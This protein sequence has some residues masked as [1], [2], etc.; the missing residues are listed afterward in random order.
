MGVG[1]FE[2]LHLSISLILKPKLPEGKIEENTN[3]HGKVQLSDARQRRRV[4]KTKPGSR[5]HPTV[6]IKQY[7]PGYTW[8]R[9]GRMKELRI[10]H[11]AR[12]Y[13]HKWKRKV[14][15]RLTPSQARHHYETRLLRRT[16]GAWHLL[17]WELRK[18]WRLEVRAECHYRFIVYQKMYR[19]WKL[20]IVQQRIRNAKES[21]ALHHAQKKLT[22]KCFDSWQSYVASRREKSGARKTALTYHHNHVLRYCWNVWQDRLETIAHRRRLETVALQFWAFRVQAQYW[23]IWQSK[24]S[25]RRAGLMKYY[26]AVRHNNMGL[27]RR[28][29]R[30]WLMYWARR[31]QKH[32]EKVYAMR[33]YTSGLVQRTFSVWLSALRFRES[34]RDRQDRITRLRERSQKRRAFVHWRHYIEMQHEKSANIA[35][36][37][38]YHRKKL[39]RLGF[40]A[41]RLSVANKHLK[42]MRNKMATHF[43][44]KRLLCWGWLTWLARCE[45]KED[46]KQVTQC[47]AAWIHR[48]RALLRKYFHQLWEYAQWRKHRQAQYARADAH[49]YMQTMPKYLFTLKV[50]VQ[51]M[52][53]RRENKQKSLEFRRENMLARFFYGWISQQEQSKEYR[54]NERMA[55]IHCED[56]TTQCFFKLWKSKTAESLKEKKNMELAAAHYNETLLATH[57]ASWRGYIQDL[58]KSQRQE[59]EA[60]RYQ[61]RH[62]MKKCIHAWK[63]YA[64]TCREKHR[65]NSKA[66]NHYNRRLMGKMVAMWLHYVDTQRAIKARVEIMYRKKCQQLVCEL[67][68]TWRSNV[69]LQKS[70]KSSEV[71]ADRH[72]KLTLCRK[73]FTAWHRFSAIHAYKKSET[74][75]WVQSARQ[76]L[77]QRMLRLYFSTWRSRHASHVDLRLKLQRAVDHHGNMIKA[78]VMTQWKLF[79]K[80]AVRKT[81]LRKQCTWFHNVRVTGCAFVAWKKAHTVAM[82]E[83]ER[84]SLALWHWSLGLQR[85]VLMGWFTCMLERRLKKARV[86]S[87]M[88]RRRTRLIKDGLIKWLRVAD[89]LTCM[90]KTFAVQ[91]QAKSAYETYQVALRCGLHWKSWAHRRALL[92]SK[93]KPV[94]KRETT[95]PASITKGEKS[96]K[97][98]EDVASNNTTPRFPVSLFNTPRELPNSVPPCRVDLQPPAPVKMA[99]SPVRPA[100]QGR[101]LSRARPRQPDFLVASLKRAGLIVGDT[102]GV[103]AQPGSQVSGSPLS[104]VEHQPPASII[105][106]SEIEKLNLTMLT[107]VGSESESARSVTPHLVP[108][109]HGALTSKAGDC[110][111]NKEPFSSYK[112]DGVLY[113]LQDRVSVREKGSSLIHMRQLNTDKDKQS[114][115]LVNNNTGYNVPTKV[116]NKVALLTPNDFVTK[117][118]T[119]VSLET[120]NRSQVLTP[121]SVVS[122]FSSAQSECGSTLT[123]PRIVCENSQ[124]SHPFSET[125]SFQI[126][127]FQEQVTPRSCTSGFTPRAQVSSL[128]FDAH[129]TQSKQFT[130]SRKSAQSELSTESIQKEIVTIR[131]KLKAFDQ[132]KKKVR[133]MQ[134]QLKQ[135]SDWL[136]EMEG[137][138]SDDD[139]VISARQEVKE[140]TADIDVLKKSVEQEKT[141]CAALV[142]R[143][144]QLTSRLSVS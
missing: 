136:R 106:S 141:T 56:K 23:L 33:I 70:E 128:G 19:A 43:R 131:N 91:Q 12:K 71:V 50:F 137:Q 78:K 112:N 28:C 96:L 47:H 57:L 105:D 92:R 94:Q 48:R 130:Q 134:K 132:K 98:S 11:L 60:A 31:R 125:K 122:G 124:H 9:G 61:S 93:N 108:S 88:E 2:L 102:T 79:T 111:L 45:D 109:S 95:L 63:K 55:I 127:D 87:A 121:R 49:F 22:R 67:F 5:S 115:P 34:V 42:V 129:F 52:K 114:V 21:V 44:Y 24:M 29:F 139:D 90:R 1:G 135:L 103:E 73:V 13:L 143:V 68:Q 40:S 18:E 144:K 80:E 38:N 10:R 142:D 32:Q 83:K 36:A 138:G 6:D 41:F 8:N 7:R 126:S 81:L 113:S 119:Q 27:T 104:K 30:A 54:M 26:S 51:V 74:R 4:K 15:G 123:T 46:L 53:I 100:S 89:D 25:E 116:I 58:K 107:S 72:H 85:K 117:T 120:G 37:E 20:F 76:Q 84:T 65:K 140:L 133:T 77:D 59:V 82:L 35:M 99:A 110:E 69:V 118:T 101:G 17:W 66:T 14:F 75:Q 16:F 64:I 3:N 62:L 86:Q 97:N 39:L